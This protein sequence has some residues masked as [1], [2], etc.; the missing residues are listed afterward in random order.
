MLLIL[1]SNILEAYTFGSFLSC[2]NVSSPVKG[3]LLLDPI[4]IHLF[5]YL[6]TFSILILNLFPTVGSFPPTYKQMVLSPNSKRKTSLELLFPSAR[7]YVQLHHLTS[8]KMFIH[9]VSFPYLRITLVFTLGQ[10]LSLTT[11]QRITFKRIPIIYK[12][13]NG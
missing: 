9:T 4:P 12:L 8:Q 11:A 7:F 13:P 1:A 5:H 2:W 3:H 6:S 10:C